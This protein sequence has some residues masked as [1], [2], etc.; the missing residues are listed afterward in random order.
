VT[1]APKRLI[2]ALW[3]VQ[4]LLALTYL[5]SGSMKLLLPLD[6]LTQ[7]TPLPGAFVR[8]LGLAELLGALGL[9]LPGLLRV[10]PGL[11]PLAATGLAVI[12]AGA[13][14]CSLAWGYGLAGALLPLVL[15]LLDAFV[16]YGRWRP[17]PHRGSPRPA[18]LR[19]IA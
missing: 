7:Q 2:V 10:R 5:M 19:A 4:V 12:M 3:T 11:T 13:V 18:L 14:V 6:L 17:A 9:L 16:A 8:F 15:G 1:T